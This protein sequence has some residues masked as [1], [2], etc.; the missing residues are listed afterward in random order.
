[1]KTIKRVK[2]SIE[3]G[4]FRQVDCVPMLLRVLSDDC[5]CEAKVHAVACLAALAPDMAL[6]KLLELLNSELLLQMEVLEQ[7]RSFR[8][9]PE[10]QAAV[11]P[12]LSHLDPE[13]RLAAL[14]V[15]K[16]VRRGLADDYSAVVLYA[17]SQ[18]AA[19]EKADLQ[20]LGKLLEHVDPSRGRDSPGTDR[21][22][23]TES[24][25]MILLYAYKSMS[26]SHT[27]LQNL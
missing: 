12:L 20:A 26:I 13:V 25:Y 15:T 1:M 23:N 17:L 27:V 11:Q 18:M 9:S 3:I 21:R 2:D 24:V 19:P 8:E 10:V 22:P 7:L 4:L 16:D 6:P 5:L 14:R